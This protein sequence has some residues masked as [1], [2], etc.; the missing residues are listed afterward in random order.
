MKK[1]GR[2]E[3]AT[4]A[5]ISTAHISREDLDLLNDVYEHR[6]KEIDDPDHWISDLNWASYPYGY[7]VNAHGLIRRLEEKKD[8]TP[9]FLLE[10]AEMARD[11]KLA[12]IVYDEDG[13]TLEEM[14]NY[15]DDHD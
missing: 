13:D 1:W 3:T 8:Q 11:L 6:T 14:T 15:Y 10:A 12:W 7:I 5:T 4:I 2:I 9:A